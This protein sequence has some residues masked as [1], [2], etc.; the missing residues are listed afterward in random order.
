MNDIIYKIKWWQKQNKM[1]NIVLSPSKTECGIVVYVIF[2]IHIFRAE[3]L[4]M[5]SSLTR[6][7]PL[8][9]LLLGNTWRFLYISFKQLINFIHYEITAI[10]EIIFRQDSWNFR[11]RLQKC[12]TSEARHSDD[13]LFK[14]KQ[15]YKQNKITNI[16]VSYSKIEFWVGS[17][18]PSLYRI[19][20]GI[21]ITVVRNGHSKLSLNPWWSCLHFT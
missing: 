16:V 5:D 8:W 10:T 2:Y 4:F 20:W 15:W 9:L 17:M 1:A 3:K 19:T 21:M 7:L 6:S 12:I 11:V 18:L 13:I 14:T